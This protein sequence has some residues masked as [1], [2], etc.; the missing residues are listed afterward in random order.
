MKN[1]SKFEVSSEA[2]VEYKGIELIVE[3]DAVLILEKLGNDIDE[4]ELFYYDNCEIGG[5]SVAGLFRYPNKFEDSIID[6]LKDYIKNNWQE[7][8]NISIE[9]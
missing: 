9:V 7:L 4:P 3:F 6:V 1:L 8:H 5:W 2:I